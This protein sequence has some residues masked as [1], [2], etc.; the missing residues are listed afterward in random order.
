MPTGTITVERPRYRDDTTFPRDTL[1]HARDGSV[2]HTTQKVK[3]K[4][5][6]RFTAFMVSATFGLWCFG[7]HKPI[8]GIRD[9][10]ISPRD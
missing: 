1:I 10:R 9:E 4:R 6:S 7:R 8:K 5:W 2:Y 3:L